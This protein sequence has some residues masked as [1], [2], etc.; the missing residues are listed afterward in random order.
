MP[1]AERERRA[2][3][4][5][6]VD[7]SASPA[8]MGRSRGKHVTMADRPAHLKQPA[9]LSENP[10]VPKPEEKRAPEHDPLGLDPTR[11]GDWELK[12]IAIDF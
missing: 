3:R 9:Y 11:Y 8:H 1:R 12:G 10:P 7:D 2:G 5:G 6:E 4:L